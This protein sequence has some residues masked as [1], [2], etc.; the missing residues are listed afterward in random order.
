MK[1]LTVAY[2]IVCALLMVSATGFATEQRMR[3]YAARLLEESSQAAASGRHEDALSS[4]E[5][6]MAYDSRMIVVWY[7]ATNHLRL[8]H[9]DLAAAYLDRYLAHAPRHRSS[10]EMQQA[11]AAI[12]EAGAE[13]AD[14]D[15]R[16]QL[17]AQL[18]S[19]DAAVRNG[20]ARTA[21]GSDIRF[22][23][24]ADT[25]EA[26]RLSEAARNR[27]TELFQSGLRATRQ[28][29]VD[30]AL[31]EFERSLAYRRIRNAVYNISVCHLM[32]GHR[33]LASHFLAWYLDNQPE[34]ASDPRVQAVERAID[35]SPDDVGDRDRRI[36]LWENLY[37]GVEEPMVVTAGGSRSREVPE[38]LDRSLA[39]IE[40]SFHGIV[41][42][43][44][45]CRLLS[46]A[47]SKNER[48]MHPPS[49]MG[50]CERRA[51]AQSLA[52]IYNEVDRQLQTG[53][54][55]TQIDGTRCIE[56]DPDDP[57]EFDLTAISPFSNETTWSAI[58]SE[59]AR[60]CEPPRTASAPS[61]RGR[62]PADRP[63]ADIRWEV[64]RRTID[65][66]PTGVEVGDRINLRGD[67]S[68]DPSGG[69][70]TYRWN[71]CRPSGD[72]ETLPRP[73]MGQGD[74]SRA[75]FTI[76]EEGPHGV[77]LV[78]T[79]RSGRSNGVRVRIPVGQV[80]P[81]EP[82][83][84]EVREVVYTRSCSGNPHPN[85]WLECAIQD[86]RLD[87]GGQRML[88][89]YQNR[90]LDP[91][92]LRPGDVCAAATAAYQR[93]EEEIR[94]DLTRRA[95][96]RNVVS[97]ISSLLSYEEG[98]DYNYESFISSFM[99]LRN[100]VRDGARRLMSAVQTCNLRGTTDLAT[101]RVNMI[102]QRWYED[103]QRHS[104][105]VYSVVVE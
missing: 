88:R 104:H 40:E 92:Y 90:A 24:G 53:N 28:R 54:E 64:S 78:V 99:S 16:R 102:F 63:T 71:L 73:T 91:P 13:L 69:P 72:C 11:V 10:L 57:L 42:N 1:P 61:G 7:I 20:T 103:Q 32:L 9:G 36:L 41:G 89:A 37:D 83:R 87:S 98:S 15:L 27:G 47:R 35:E 59:E 29:N 81:D 21:E 100:N 25:P 33:D 86:S 38:H 85:R 23:V 34:A 19:A 82:D 79:S 12:A 101:P 58:E 2:R 4:L 75:S 66:E 17:A 26:R 31:R 56:W 97:A 39:M 70:L 67:G 74:G 6:S 50:P 55:P 14:D 8:G 68:S 46:F 3:E 52:L 51:L 43:N 5:A 60:R 30:Q 105:S 65:D 76:D 49:P 48:L 96:R 22:G 44:T 93:D 84:E 80:P 18:R 77:E 94:A 62:P 45:T 95:G